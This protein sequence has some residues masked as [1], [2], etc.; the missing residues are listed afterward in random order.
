DLGAVK[1][2]PLSLDVAQVDVLIKSITIL[3]IKNLLMEGRDVVTIGDHLADVG[4]EVVQCPLSL[5]DLPLPLLGLWTVDTI[6]P[7][8]AFTVL[9]LPNLIV[10]DGLAVLGRTLRRLLSWLGL[11]D[12]RRL[13]ND[14]TLLAQP[15]RRID[16][17]TVDDDAHV[18]MSPVLAGRLNVTS[19]S[20][21]ADLLAGLDGLP[22][23]HVVGVQ[24]SIIGQNS[25]CVLDQNIAIARVSL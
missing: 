14:D 9:V 4:L 10:V 1:P 5:S 19:V 25:S 21:D 24:V 20:H 16:K 12:G 23:R 17:H 2:H 8:S 11:L 18:E 22:D 7:K 15:D 6:M 3:D 13:T